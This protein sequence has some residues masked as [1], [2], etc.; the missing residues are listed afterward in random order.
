MPIPLRVPISTLRLK[1]DP[2]GILMGCGRNLGQKISEVLVP[3]ME[4][5]EQVRERLAKSGKKPNRAHRA[6]AL[7]QEGRWAP[8][9]VAWK[10]VRMAISVVMPATS[11]GDD[12][13]L[14][15]KLGLMCVV[16]VADVC[17]VFACLIA[18]SFPS[19]VDQ[20]RAL[21]PTQ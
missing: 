13:A 12:A 20:A 9:T 10:D 18:E 19:A 11:F 5:E 14:L 4:E 1:L 2:D 8:G 6:R 3:L 15:V 17:V 16:K 21:T 7:A